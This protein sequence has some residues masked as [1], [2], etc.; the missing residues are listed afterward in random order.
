MAHRPTVERRRP[1]NTVYAAPVIVEKLLLRRLGF[2]PNWV[3]LRSGELEPLV[4][5]IDTLIGNSGVEVERIEQHL[6]D[7]AYRNG[8]QPDAVRRLL[9]KRLVLFRKH[10]LVI[11]TRKIRRAAEAAV[12]SARTRL[13]GL[14]HRNHSTVLSN[15]QSRRA[16]LEA[17]ELRMAIAWRSMSDKIVARLREATPRVRF[18]C[19]LDAADQR[20]VSDWRRDPKRTLDEETNRLESA[21]RAEKG[22]LAYY[23]SLG[24]QVEDVSIQQL[25]EGA[26]EDWKTHDIRADAR[27]LDVKNV[28]CSRP[29]RFGE[30]HWKE[31]KLHRTREVPIVG[32]VSMEDGD[33]GVST[34]TGELEHS[35]LA[36][37]SDQ[38]ASYPR[39][40]KISV[41]FGDWSTFVPGWLFEYPKR[42]YASMPDWDDVLRRWLKICDGLSV[43]V[44]PWILA[45]AASRMRSLP[46]RALGARTTGSVHRF[47]RHFGVSRRTLFWFAL[48]YLLSHMEEP[49]ARDDLLEQIFPDRAT[50]ACSADRSSKEEE[51][52]LALFDPRMY[53]WHLIHTLSQ[54]IQSNRRLLATVSEYRLRGTGILQA[55][56]EGRWRTVLAYC[57]NCGKWPIFLGEISEDDC[58]RPVEDGACRS[59]PCERARLV[60]DDCCACAGFDCTGKQY[61]TAAEAL[62]AAREFPGWRKIGNRL[63]PPDPDGS[64]FVHPGIR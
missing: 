27:P 29:G 21:R 25:R 59:C 9:S 3:S 33:P 52:P 31:H 16:H 41:E 44:A 63:L 38:V 39:D 20:L 50:A 7:A 36:C 18:R 15:I 42:H 37:F 53:I 48:T 58:E 40:Q 8:V 34:I 23:S 19:E 32:V 43:E 26:P 57:G 4:A 10:R 62:R 2:R 45:L 55:L 47:F 28:R 17:L 54:M 56:V 12:G 14:A 24:Y 22:S 11:Q 64:P 46:N 49:R 6:L 30:H 13:T 61:A 35:D 51:F 60:C 1:R 5:D